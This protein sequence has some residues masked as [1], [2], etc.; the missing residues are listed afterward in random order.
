MEFKLT[1]LK[2]YNKRNAKKNNN[3][4]AFDPFNDSV[5]VNTNLFNI[6]NSPDAYIANSKKEFK[7]AKKTDFEFIYYNKKGLLYYNENG[8]SKKFGKGGIIAIFSKRQNLDSNF[9]K[10]NGHPITPTSDPLQTPSLALPPTDLSVSVTTFA[11]NIASGSIVATLK[12]LDSNSADTHT[13]SL[14]SGDGAEDNGFFAI[15][16]NQI[17]IKESPDFE[18]QDSY[19]IRLATKDS[20]GLTFEKS[21]T[22]TIND[23]NEY[24]TDLLVSASSFDEHIS[25]GSNVSS[26]QTTDQDAGDIYTYSLFW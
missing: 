20:G 4:K 16:N 26:L 5:A 10:F 11:E 25:A 1:P 14:I 22:L 21:F 23:L 9:F 17:K 8:G 12:S 13:Y 19:S 3:F 15:I 18:T 24:P 2:K 6:S 7:K